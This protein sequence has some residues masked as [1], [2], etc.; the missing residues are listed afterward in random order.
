[1]RGMEY[2]IAEFRI[3]EP[4]P[5][6]QTALRKGAGDGGPNSQSLNKQKKGSSRLGTNLAPQKEG[7]GT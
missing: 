3:A 6:G 1:M 2:L 7:M 5:Y 4:P